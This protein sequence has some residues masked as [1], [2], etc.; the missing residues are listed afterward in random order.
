MSD[1]I[2]KMDNVIAIIMGGGQGKRLFPLTRVRSKP[3]V[4]IGGKYRLVDIP[5]SNSLNSGIRRICVLTQ[6]NSTSL[7]RHIHRA[8]PYEHF[9][10]TSVELL[11]AEQTPSHMEWFQGTA[12]AVR[13]HM[14][15]YHLDGMDAVLVLSGDHLYRMD[16][17]RIVKFHHEKNADVTI[18]T[19]PVPKKEVSQFGILQIHPT[20]QITAF[21]EK[22]SPSEKIHSYVIPQT[23]RHIFDLK[24]KPEAY[25]ASMGV[26]VFKPNVLK[27]LLSGNEADFGKEVIPKAIKK[28]KA[29][30]F[31][32]S[33]YWRDIGTIRAFYDASIELTGP[34]PPFSFFSPNARIF[35]R[36]RFLPPS[37]IHEAHLKNVLMSEGCFLRGASVEDSV[38]GL[39]SIIREGTVIRRS[40]IMGNDFYEAESPIAPAV[41]GIGRNCVIENCIL[42]KN[43][44]IGNHVAIAGHHG[45]KDMD[46]ENFYIRD[47]IVII[48]K[49][50]VIPDGTKI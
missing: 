22:P 21:R 46:G 24:G 26:Y 36:P 32:F 49:D 45:C 31:V 17:R 50:A 48:P 41:L 47:G 35:T 3:A 2:M 6:F 37:N 8:Y 25:L 9:N 27:D 10:Q 15:H 13:K 11:A 5:I 18:A 19:V 43:V 30:G 7:H 33:D 20:G 4:P 44:R 38:I 23:I 14:P 28:F 12:D 1:D 29:F 42:D 39:R 16:Y 34:N 40:V